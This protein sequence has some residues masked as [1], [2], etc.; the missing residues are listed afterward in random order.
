MQRV[1]TAIGELPRHPGHRR[2]IP[3]PH[4]RVICICRITV[5]P[6]AE[7]RNNQTDLTNLPRRHHVL[8]LAHHR[9]GRIAIIHRANLPRGLS[10]LHDLLTLLDSHGHR[11]FA[12]HIKPCLKK[13]F[14]DL[15]VRRI[16][17]GDSH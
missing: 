11:L 1:N 7:I 9:V 17:R 16:R 15:K 14:G 5:V 4:T 12:Q 8:H 6:V 2:I 13:G 10:D 3:P